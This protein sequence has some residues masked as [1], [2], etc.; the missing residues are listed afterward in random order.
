MNLRGLISNSEVNVLSEKIAKL[1][2]ESLNTEVDDMTHINNLIE[3]EIDEA[4][5][6]QQMDNQLAEVNGGSK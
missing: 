6:T 1:I 4:Y 2:D 3:K 5:R